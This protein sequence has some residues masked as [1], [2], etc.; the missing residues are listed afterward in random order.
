MI[1]Y[2]VQ[3]YQ[4]IITNFTFN[5]CLCYSHKYLLFSKD[6]SQKL[7][8]KIS[9]I[10]TQT[11]LRA[12][13]LSITHH[14]LLLLCKYTINLTV[15]I[16]SWLYLSWSILLV[17]MC[18]LKSYPFFKFIIKF[19]GLTTIN[20]IVDFKCTFCMIHNL[21]INLCAHQLKL[22][23]LKIFLPFNDRISIFRQ[24]SF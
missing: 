16:Y 4:V 7:A 13:S 22:N 6:P 3:C 23:L 8:F 17:N 1:I 21:Y 20:K 2:I 18:L 10:W 9:M 14:M 24:K 11:S 5:L 19:N 15:V 12:L